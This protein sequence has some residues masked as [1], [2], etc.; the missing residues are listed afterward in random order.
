VSVDI[1]YG[2]TGLLKARLLAEGHCPGLQEHARRQFR[3]C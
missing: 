1:L 3:A 2:D